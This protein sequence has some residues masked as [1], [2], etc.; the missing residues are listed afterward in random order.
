MTDVGRDRPAGGGRAP[1]PE[2]ARGEV[3]VSRL[4]GGDAIVDVL[5]QGVP[6]VVG[7]HAL[8]LFDGIALIDPGPEACLDALQRGLAELGHRLSDVRAVLLTHIH[9]DHAAA[10]GALAR[11]SPG[12]RVYVH[13]VG[14]PHMADPARLLASAGRIYGV[15]MSTLWG[16][17]LP[18]PE[19]SL[20]PVGEGDVV[21]LGDRELQVAD[22]PG[23]AKH[24]VAYYEAATGTAWVGD[25]GGIRIGSGPPIP[26]TPPPDIDVGLWKDS[27]DRVA[28]WRPD[29]IA[30]THFGAFQDA[31]LH[32][33]RLRRGLDRWAA[34]VRESLEPA[35]D[36]DAGDDDARAQA[37]ADWATAEL[38]AEASA[39]LVETYVFA[40][41]LRDSWRGLARYW[42]RRDRSRR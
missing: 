10:T 3:H 17:F 21:T 11:R 15:R 7:V 28:A 22:T 20:V 29:R 13:P 2:R 18:V 19:A 35:P 42:R 32:F 14:A 9:L 34:W 4:D 24:H 33:E 6:R 5:H 39:E 27:M 36:S 12:V 8:K 41:G 38:E 31:E 1:A 37:F 26:V 23:H 40:S 25:V 30:P 16:E